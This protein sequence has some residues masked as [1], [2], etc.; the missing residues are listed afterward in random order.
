MAGTLPDKRCS[1]DTRVPCM[2]CAITSV[3]THQDMKDLMISR[4][5]QFGEYIDIALAN[6]GAAPLSD[7]LKRKYFR[8]L[9]LPEDA[10]GKG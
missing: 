4:C 1:T 7:E 5:I 9:G 6:R 8:T 3:S 10:V 2:G